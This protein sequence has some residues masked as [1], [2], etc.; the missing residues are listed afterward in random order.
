MVDVLPEIERFFTSPS[1]INH[2]TLFEK[3]GT[4]TANA[5]DISRFF[6]FQA[7]EQYIKENK[8]ITNGKHLPYNP[9]LKE[10]AREMRKNQTPMEQKLWKEFFQ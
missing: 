2:P 1:G 10:R 6:D 5:D 9:I 7:N 3:E 4:E 8:L